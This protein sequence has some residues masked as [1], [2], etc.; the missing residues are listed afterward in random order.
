MVVAVVA[1]LA[2]RAGLF[3]LHDKAVL[4]AAID[5][6]RTVPFVGVLFV[7]TY[8]IGAAFGVPATP[9][10]LAGGA[11]FGISEGIALNWLGEMAAASIA[12]AV[13][14]ATGIRTGAADTTEASSPGSKISNG[15]VKLFRLRLIP[16]APFA[17]LNAGAAVSGMSWRDYTIATGAGIIPITVIYTVSASELIAGVAGSS[18]KALTKALISAATLIGLTLLPAVVRRLRGKT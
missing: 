17:L 1:T 2:W 4:I 5:R 16:V 8:A 9:L 13:T 12:F 15:M 7:A 6:A 14:R 10:T 11:L 3:K 18:T